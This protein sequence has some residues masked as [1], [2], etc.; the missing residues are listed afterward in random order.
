MQNVKWK[1]QIVKNINKQTISWKYNIA[2]A[3]YTDAF[4]INYLGKHIHRKIINK[5]INKKSY[6]EFSAELIVRQNRK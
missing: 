3:A 4:T 2:S 5:L 6:L 1:K